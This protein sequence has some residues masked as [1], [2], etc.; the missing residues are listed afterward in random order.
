MDDVRVHGS[1]HPQRQ[2]SG[3]MKGLMRAGGP[4]SGTTYLSSDV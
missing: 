4:G 3:P 2:V 1:N